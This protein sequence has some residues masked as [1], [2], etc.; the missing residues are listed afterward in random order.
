MPVS[1]FVSSRDSFLRR[2]VKTALP[3]ITKAVWEFE[4]SL[5][6]INVW[7]YNNVKNLER[8]RK[9][10]YFRDSLCWGL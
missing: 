1:F 7:H 4:I 9:D 5:D 2:E 3:E 6:K 8:I 10:G